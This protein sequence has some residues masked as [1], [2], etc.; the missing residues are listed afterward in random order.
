MEALAEDISESASGSRVRKEDS[1]KELTS[2]IELTW[3]E[4]I[5]A[6]KKLIAKRVNEQ[7]TQSLLKQV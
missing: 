2:V 5:R 6:I 3:K 7:L 4:N 1:F